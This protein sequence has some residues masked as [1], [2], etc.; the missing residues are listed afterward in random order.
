MSYLL[1]AL[2]YKES[3]FDKQWIADAYEKCNLEDGDADLKKEFR[4]VHL[5]DDIHIVY[6]FIQGLETKTQ[7]FNAQADF[8]FE[9]GFLGKLFEVAK[10]SKKSFR[11]FFL[12][13]N[14]MSGPIRCGTVLVNDDSEA[15]WLEGETGSIYIEKKGKMV[16]Q[17]EKEIDFDDAPFL[18]EDGELK[19]EDGYFK[20][21]YEAQKPYD[22]I[23]FLNEQYGITRGNV[24]DGL[25]ECGGENDELIAGSNQ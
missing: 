22:G 24:F 6:F 14:D 17:V 5:K 21:Q 10:K 11:Y 7:A 15:R 2:I 1:T 13:Y 23:A 3:E 4:R 25:Y 12:K 20:A 8:L 18:D 16:K 19:D 9:S